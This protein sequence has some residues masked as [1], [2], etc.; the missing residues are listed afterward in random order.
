MKKEDKGKTQKESVSSI[1]IYGTEQSNINWV[2]GLTLS[3]VCP[4]FL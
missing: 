3:E 1:S 2:E 4:F